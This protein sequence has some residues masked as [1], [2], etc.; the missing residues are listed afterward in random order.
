MLDR[1]ILEAFHQYL[2]QASPAMRQFFGTTHYIGRWGKEDVVD[3]YGDVVARSYLREGDWIRG[4]DEL[5]MMTNAIFRQASFATTV[6]VPNIFH[7]KVPADCIE[8]YLN[9]HQ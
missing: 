9:L 2:G 5:K 6:E 8:R 3:A 1:V 7:G 4:H